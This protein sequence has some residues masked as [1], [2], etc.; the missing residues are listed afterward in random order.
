MSIL[1]ECKDWFVSPYLRAMQ[2][3]AYALA[4]LRQRDPGLR[5]RVTPLANEIV[6]STL[7]QDCQG[8]RGNIGFRVAARAVGKISETMEE[9]EEDFQSRTRNIPVHERQ[10]ELRDVSATLCAMDLADVSQVWWADVTAF[11]KEHLRL[12]DMRVRRL[13]ATLLKHEANVVGVVAHS[14]LFQ[15]LIQLFWPHDR[16]LQEELRTSMR[17]GA[18]LETRDPLHDK[19]MNCGT[20]VLKW[21]YWS[22]DDAATVIHRSDAEI[23]GA[24]FLF[25][26]RMESAQPLDRQGFDLPDGAMA[27]G[28]EDISAIIGDIPDAEGSPN[29]DCL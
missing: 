15:R 3:A 7:S 8:K 9:E 17:N 2:T 27:E 6:S 5:I 11:K 29:E 4:P 16:G 12:E 13:A 18:P 21:R 20:L 19:I 1:L 10:E 26:G 14:L 25:G 24:K 28:L 22:L 23:V